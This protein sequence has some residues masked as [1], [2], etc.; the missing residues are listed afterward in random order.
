MSLTRDPALEPLKPPDAKKLARDIV[1]NGMVEVSGHA[2]EEMANDELQT[3]DCVNLLRA[4][5]WEP[6]EYING[7]W[8]Y[9]VRTA[10]MC[11]VIAF[12]SDT[13]LRMVTAWRIK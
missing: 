10:R 7:Q 6:P 13:R 12:A 1:E 5:V 9:R 3:T 11:V 4:G 2:R 8:R